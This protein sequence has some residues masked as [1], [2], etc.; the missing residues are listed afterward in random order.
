MRSEQ[1]C[2]VPLTAPFKPMDK[3][4]FP[5]HRYVRHLH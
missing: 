2:F 4:A 1:T 5:T 3:H